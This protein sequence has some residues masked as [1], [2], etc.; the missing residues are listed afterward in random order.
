[1]SDD[2]KVN[3]AATNENEAGADEVKD[4]TTNKNAADEADEKENELVAAA[5]IETKIENYENIRT[6]R[7]HFSQADGHEVK[8]VTTEENAADAEGAVVTVEE[9]TAEAEEAARV[10][11]K[12]IENETTETEEAARVER[13][14]IEFCEGIRTQRKHFPGSTTSN[15]FR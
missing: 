5:G 14:E 8:D 13:K 15:I 1:M 4:V 10:E 12:K 11:R 6:Q 3:T 7:R 2:S 9:E